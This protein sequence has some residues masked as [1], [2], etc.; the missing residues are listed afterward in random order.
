MSI[1]GSLNTILSQKC[2]ILLQ[3][4]TQYLPIVKRSPKNRIHTEFSYCQ[5]CIT[6]CD[7]HHPII[8]RSSPLNLFEITVVHFF[9]VQHGKHSPTQHPFQQDSV[10]NRQTQLIQY[11]QDELALSPDALTLASRCPHRTATQIPIILW[12]YGLVNLQQ[13]EQIFDWLASI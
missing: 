11:L 1:I 12:Q 10:M 5:R 4:C 7:S 9:W 3:M 2:L 6:L 8:L 13:L